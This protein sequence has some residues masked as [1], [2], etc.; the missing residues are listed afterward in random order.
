MRNNNPNVSL[1][2]DLN[3]ATRLRRAIIL[4]DAV[5]V[6]RIVKNNPGK[7]RNPDLNDN[8]NTSLHLA[9]QLGFLEI[10]V[11]RLKR[12]ESENY[13]LMIPKQ[14]LVDYGHEDDAISSNVTWDTPLHLAVETSVPI[15]VFLATKFPQCIPW[16]NKQG[17]DVVRYLFHICLYKSATDLLYL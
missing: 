10:A 3:V 15:A 14:L 13:I 17:A 11:S 8:G 6:K 16:K 2:T 5:L 1:S 7:V 4:N 12:H 9:A